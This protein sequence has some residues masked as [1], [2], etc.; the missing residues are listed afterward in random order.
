MLPCSIFL[1]LKEEDLA[2]RHHPTVTDLRHLFFPTFLDS[3]SLFPLAENKGTV[4][5]GAMAASLQQGRQHHTSIL[6]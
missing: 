3:L 1:M 6:L 4:P 5:E 2:S